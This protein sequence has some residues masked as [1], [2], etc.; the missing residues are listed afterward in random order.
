MYLPGS[1]KNPRKGVITTDTSEDEV[2]KL[3]N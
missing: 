1:Q 3:K 2:E